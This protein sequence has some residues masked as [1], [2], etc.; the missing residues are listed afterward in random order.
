MPYEMIY[1]DK[2]Y[3]NIFYLI[4]LKIIIC[5]YPITLRPKKKKKKKKRCL[6][7]FSD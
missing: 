4:Y 7:A 3:F 5:S 1:Q 2:K 6:F